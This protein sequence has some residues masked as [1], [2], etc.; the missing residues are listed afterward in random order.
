MY[1]AAARY[2][3][4]AASVDWPTMPG[5]MDDDDFARFAVSAVREYFEKNNSLM[6]KYAFKGPVLWM[7]DRSASTLKFFDNGKLHSTC[8]VIEIGSFSHSN[9]SWKWG[10][11]DDAIPQRSRERAL[12]L[13][14]LQRITGKKYFGSEGQFPVSD[15]AM[16]GKLAAISVRQLSAL[17]HYSA[18]ISDGSTASLALVDIQVE[19]GTS[20]EMDDNDFARFAESA[21]KE[22]KEKD[23]DLES[24]YRFDLSARWECD[25]YAA[26]PIIK[27]FDRNDK[28][29][30]TCEVIEIGTYSPPTQSWKWG[31]SNDSIPP[32]MRERALP[33]KQLQQITGKDYF[34]FEGPFSADDLMAWEL[35]AISVRHLSALGCYAAKYHD[36]RLF[37]FL[38]YV[39]VHAES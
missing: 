22:L 15:E 24:K 27:F 6:T 35:A 18:E 36:G 30:L 23:N 19:T 29:H 34:G 16:A 13:K 20:R 4:I 14:K 11:S 3:Q 5:E 26:L 39:N 12:P 17:G 25:L 10:W 9:R 31:W 32:K 28:L 37:V 21:V 1:W 38:A 33:L 8:D 2:P 7:Y